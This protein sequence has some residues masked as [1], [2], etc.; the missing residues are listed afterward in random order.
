MSLAHEAMLREWPPAVRWIEQNRHWLRL[1][2]VISAAAALYGEDRKANRLLKG[3]LL[4]D[5]KNLLAEHREILGLNE[6]AF[7]EHSSKHY[8]RQLRQWFYMG[9]AA[10]VSVVLLVLAAVFGTS[11]IENVFWALSRVPD[12]WQQQG[13]PPLSGDG[14][15]NLRGSIAE[16]ASHLNGSAKQ[17]DDKSELVPWTVAQIFTSLSGL[18]G[19]P[20]AQAK[21]LRDFMDKKK[22][23]KCQCWREDDISS[24]HSM[25]TAWVLLALALYDEPAQAKEIAQLLKRQSKEG[26]WSMFPLA[27]L[28]EERSGASASTSA[29]AWTAFALHTQLEHKLIQNADRPKVE[30]SI[31]RAVKWLKKIA[32]SGQARWKEYPPENGFEKDT[33][34]MAV[35]ALVIYVLRAIEKESNFDV[36]WL[37]ALPMVAPNP[38]DTEVAKGYVMGVDAGDFVIKFVLDST[39]HYRYPWMLQTTVDAYAQGT[40]WQRARAVVWLEQTLS[41]KLT[42]ADFETGTGYEDWRMA[43]TLFALRHVLAVVDPSSEVAKVVH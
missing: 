38:K 28:D 21:H 3:A 42:S 41:R 32:L 39:R 13:K 11:E 29:T 37:E 43:E 8:R 20:S 31:G 18:D 4:H 23:E 35:S 25:V 12:A 16:L 19:G 36:K 26:W 17:I 14:L 5:A 10:A 7:I 15:A 33:D 24:P 30:D 34:Y 27:N 1:R 2:G 40:V 9:A 6:R 22:Y